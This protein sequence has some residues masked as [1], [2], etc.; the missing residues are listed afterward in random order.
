MIAVDVFV[1]NVP[2]NNPPADEPPREAEEANEVVDLVIFWTAPEPSSETAYFL[3]AGELLGNG[4][5]E[6]G[7]AR[8]AHADQHDQMSGHDNP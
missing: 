3:K 8:S 5:D 2:L 1:V 4:V 6:R 7:L